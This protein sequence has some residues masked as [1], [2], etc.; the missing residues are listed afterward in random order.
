[1]DL[2]HRSRARGGLPARILVALSVASLVA[3]ALMPALALATST[4][5]SSP[6]TVSGSQP[7]ASIPFVV[8]GSG[9]TATGT[10][11]L[12]LHWTQDASLGTTFDPNLVRQGRSL[13]PSD[14][15]GRTAAGSMSV[16]YTLHNLEVS[17]DG[18]GPLSLG[19]PTFTTSGA[20]DLAAGGSDYACHLTSGSKIELFP[21]PPGVIYG[22]IGPYVDLSLATDVTVTADGIATL[23]TATFGGNP[24]GTA[25]LALGESPITDGLFIPCSVGKGDEMSDALGGL[26]TSP[27]VSVDTSLVFEVGAAF[28][29]P[30]IPGLEHKVAFGSPS[31]DAGTV[32]GSITLTGAGATFDLGAVQPNNIPPGVDAGGPYAGD[33]GSP[34]TFNGSGSSSVC[35]FPTLR[36][37]FSDGGVAFGPTPQHP[38][39]DDGVYSGLLTATDATGLSSTTTF[40]VTVAN[41]PPSVDGGPDKTSLWGVPVAFHANGSDP[42]P[43]DDASLLYSW[44][45]G[46]PYSPIGAVGQDVAHTYGHPGVYSAEVT[47]TDNNGATATDQVQV[48]V[49]ARATTTAYTGPLKSLPSKNVTLTA[50]LVDELGQPVVGRGVTF[51]L[52]SQTISAATNGS[53]VATATIKLNQKQGSYTVSV[54]FAGDAMYLLSS[55]SATFVIGK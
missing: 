19:S 25:N 6:T 32:G 15:Y 31:I 26:S 8:T 46:D 13:D 30:I 48:T 2:L 52:G 21:P 7:L 24:D 43:V 12:T 51:T 17:W 55:N 9:V 23:R 22:Y 16:D 14:S 53:G 42:G 1:M 41:L 38:F 11:D 34:I 28:P 3:L 45:F 27:G 54:D 36:W 33:E 47:V 20:C 29:D 10:A 4:S 50:S 18:I 39:A 40:S 35:G 37:D 5:L 49:L 44:D